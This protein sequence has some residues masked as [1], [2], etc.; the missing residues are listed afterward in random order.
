MI[1]YDSLLLLND[2]LFEF[3]SCLFQFIF[4]CRLV[5]VALSSFNLVLGNTLHEIT[6][7]VQGSLWGQ[8]IDKANKL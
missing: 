5:N 4:N 3:L 2:S 1:R 6:L 7:V 8:N